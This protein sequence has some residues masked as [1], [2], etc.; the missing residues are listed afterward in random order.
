MS[1]SQIPTIQELVRAARYPNAKPASSAIGEGLLG[2]GSQGYIAPNGSTYEAALTPT[3]NQLGFSFN[4]SV[5]TKM[6]APNDETPIKF[7]IYA[8][9]S[10]QADGD[11]FIVLDVTATTDQLG[12]TAG[13]DLA[14]QKS[15]YPSVLGVDGAIAR[16]D[17]LAGE[18]C[19]AL[20]GAG[21]LTPA[22]DHLA[23]FVVSRRS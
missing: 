16:A 7:K 13:R 17:A 6:Y 15:T 8:P 22:L 11:G 9:G 18:A 21:L 10:S 20:A 5:G 2:N 12:K 23:R 3:S 14:L 19:Q 1:V 4:F